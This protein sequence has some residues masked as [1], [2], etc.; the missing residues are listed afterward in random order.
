[1]A[2]IRTVKPEFWTHEGLSALPEPTHLLAAALLNYADDYGYFN[3]NVALIKA[4]CSPIREPSVSIPESLRSLQAA[5]Y[6][7]LGRVPDGRRYGQIVEFS[8]HQRVSHPTKSVIA[9]LSIT[10]DDSGNPPE[11][12]GNP[13]ESFRPEWNREQ[14]MEQGTGN[15]ERVRAREGEEGDK[16]RHPSEETRDSS[17]MSTPTRVG[18]GSADQEGFDRIRAA[19]PRFLGRQDWITAAHHCQ[20]RIDVDGLTW[21]DLQDAATRYAAY[22]AAGGVSGPGYV[23]RPAVFFSAAD[24]PWTQSWE[25]PPPAK[26][27]YIPAPTTEELE[28]REREREAG[29]AAQ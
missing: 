18:N 7:R 24:K 2:R 25:L 11:S 17:P 21:K 26:K 3:A 9:A 13:P 20:Q 15:R 27:P 4:A 12:G 5:R 1:M 23:L 16:A 14:G 8:K 29:R 10:W 28:A 6:V 19:Y 22:V